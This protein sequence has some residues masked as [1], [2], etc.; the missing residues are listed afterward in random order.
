MHHEGLGTHKDESHPT[1]TASYNQQD[2][3]VEELSFFPLDAATTAVQLLQAQL[4]ELK[5]SV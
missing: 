3:T 5:P 4:N 2:E 1:I